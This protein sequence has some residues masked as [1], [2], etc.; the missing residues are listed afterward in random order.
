MYTHGGITG[1]RESLSH[2]GE[3]TFSVPHEIVPPDTLE[4]YDRIE[5]PSH[6]LKLLDMYVGERIEYRGSSDAN[7][8]ACVYVIHNK[9][10][11]ED[12]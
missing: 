7:E 11:D 9:G 5:A 6:P 10:C 1:Q 2:S 3:A 4:R 8:H 12:V